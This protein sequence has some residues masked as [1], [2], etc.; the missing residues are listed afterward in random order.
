MI[1]AIVGKPD[2][3]SLKFTIN[4]SKFLY[5]YFINAMIS[6]LSISAVI[7]FFVVKPLNAL[8]ARRKAEEPTP[9]S[10]APAE[11]VRL[12]TEIRDLLAESPR[13]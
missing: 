3:S 9:E 6:F 1:A 2:F 4:S 12:L 5:G 10:D 13:A 8:A 7:F 11:D